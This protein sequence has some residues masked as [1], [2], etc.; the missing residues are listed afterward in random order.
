MGKKKS[1]GDKDIQPQYKLIPVLA[2]VI[3]AIIVGFF[4][5]RKETVL[6]DLDVFSN[7]RDTVI[8]EKI[9]LRMS[10]GTPRVSS[11]PASVLSEK[12]YNKA[13]KE[14]IAII[15]IN[16]SAL[17]QRLGTQENIYSIVHTKDPANIDPLVNNVVAVNIAYGEMTNIIPPP[18]KKHY[19]SQLMAA[20]KDYN[21]GVN[22]FIQAI[23]T[24]DDSTM[25]SSVEKLHSGAEK[26]SKLQQ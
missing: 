16:M 9:K 14:S 13:S 26:M 15:D 21:D 20:L 17:F 23:E 2:G 18:S 7:K 19:H 5:L 3:V 8:S 24:E 4:L 22:A 11:P 25:Q 1:T 6:T 10:S 12:D